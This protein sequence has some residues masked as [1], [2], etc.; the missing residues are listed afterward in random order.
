MAISDRQLKAIEAVGIK[1]DPANPPID[2]LTKTK[3]NAKGEPF[4]T[5]LGDGRGLF[6]R[7]A[8]KV[9]A[10]HEWCFDY[11][12]PKEVIAESNKHGEKL[13]ARNT[14]GCGGVF[15]DCT[16][17][18][19]R[20]KAAEYRALL[21]QGIDPGEKK[22]EVKTA[23]KE[24]IEAQTLIAARSWKGEPIELVKDSFEFV[25]RQYVDLRCTPNAQ[26][27]VDFGKARQELWKGSFERH[28]F[29]HIG[30]KLIREVTDKD[31]MRL[32]EIIEKAGTTAILHE[33]R[34]MI[35]KTFKWAIT[36]FYLDAN[37]MERIEHG[38]LIKH[39]EGNHPAI[40]KP[41]E[42]R[43]LL[44][45]LDSYGGTVEVK[46]AIR[47]QMMLWQRPGMVRFME[48]SEVTEYA[49]H[50]VWTIDSD[51]MKRSVEDKLTG[52]DHKLVL[53]PQA[54]ELLKLM[55]HF[56][57]SCQYVFPSPR[58]KTKAMGETTM[59]EALRLMGFAGKQ[60]GH[61]FRATAMTIMQQYMGIDKR[62][63]DAQM[64]HASGDNLGSAYDRAEWEVQRAL[65]GMAWPDY[66]DRLKA[67]DPK[68][69]EPYL[70]QA[71]AHLKAKA[72]KHLTLVA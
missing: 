29:P 34:R 37:P 17:D 66:L 46:G 15:P 6:L 23:I 39:I 36:R 18:M 62:L 69:Y 14:L 45:K 64:D 44:L 33:V 54:I 31:V 58:D 30:R 10:S 16:L 25:A 5:R 56:T 72:P 40:T 55:K 19:A 43:T 11:S 35:A 53:P 32:L 12:R 60:T 63:I 42:L 48:W 61:G 68:C 57:G 49:D 9:G 26:G 50:W 67:N 7:L 51:K 4:G 28:V 2:P 71:L 21:A 59:N 41:A 13:G 22:I 8:K 1:F 65:A 27:R 3:M 20:A 52:D 70:I 24:A 38:A 47:M